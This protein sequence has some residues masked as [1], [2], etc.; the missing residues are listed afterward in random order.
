MGPRPTAKYMSLHGTVTGFNTF[1][2]ERYK[3]HNPDYWVVK[4]EP[5]FLFSE[6]L[7]H[8][9]IKSWFSSRKS[10]G[11]PASW[12]SVRYGEESLQGL[13]IVRLREIAGRLRIPCQDDNDKPLKKTVLREIIAKF[14]NTNPGSQFV[15]K[16]VKCVIDG[17]EIE[18]VV[19][20]VGENTDESAG[21]MIYDVK[22][23]NGLLKGM[24]IHE[25][26]LIQ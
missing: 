7:D 21:E 5:T 19:E 6:C 2:G 14:L 20:S 8:W 25:L 26:I 10:K 1:S 18:G 9:Y 11:A 16:R 17:E 13:F 23:D 4:E 12:E 3:D 24:L 22:F 15:S